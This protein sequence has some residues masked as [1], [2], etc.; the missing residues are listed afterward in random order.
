M[1]YRPFGASGAAISNLTLSFGAAALARGRAAGLDLLYSA[2]EAGINS[3]RLETADPVAAEVLGE[4]LSHVER[5]LVQVS[6]TLGVGDGQQGPVRDFS[7]EGM[8]GAID[9][10]LHFSG[11]GWI[12]MAVL[13]EPGETELAQSSLAALKALRKT[14]R[15]RLLGIAGG[16]PVMDAYVST[17]AF[18]AL[19][20]PFDINAG[21]S[22]RNRIR[23]AREQDMA[24]FA[25]DFY[26][27]RRSREPDAPVFKKGL[28]G[29]GG[30]KRPANTPKKDAFG[31]LYRTPNWTAETICLSYVLTDP[32]VS[33]V[34]VA[35]IDT[36]RLALLAAAPERDMPPGLAAQIEMARMAANAAA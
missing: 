3:Y 14:G 10:V 15:I 18:D 1:R 6:V 25:Y 27:D 13:H 2:L 11:L 33:S 16:G 7:A 34:I 17:G 35:P 9:R 8:T 26:I 12:D 22:I 30:G 29:L 24:V 36:D 21:W 31:F 5:E 4:A 23:S 20:T 19:L 32:S 28:F